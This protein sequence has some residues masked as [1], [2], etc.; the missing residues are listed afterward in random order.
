MGEDVPQG[1]ILSDAALYAFQDQEV[2]SD[3]ISFC[4]AIPYHLRPLF[5]IPIKLQPI[6]ASLRQAAVRVAAVRVADGAIPSGG[7]EEGGWFGTRTFVY[8]EDV[9]PTI[10]SSEPGSIFKQVQPDEMTRHQNLEEDQDQN[11]QDPTDTSYM[12]DVDVTDSGFQ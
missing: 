2:F 1:F 8:D 6:T 12:S 10:P 7:T 5:L 11:W 9:E 3:L 4:S